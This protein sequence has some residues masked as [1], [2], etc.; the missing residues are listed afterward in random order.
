MNKNLHKCD[1]CGAITNSDKESSL[2]KCEYC[3]NNINY[4][5]SKS[6]K[7]KIDNYTNGINDNWS[8][9]NYDW[10]KENTDWSPE[11]DIDW[12]S[13]INDLIKELSSIKID[14][15]VLS[16]ILYYILS[17]VTC[18]F[19]KEALWGNYVGQGF[20]IFIGLGLT[21]ILFNIFEKTIR[22]SNRKKLDY[23]ILL[24][25]AIQGVS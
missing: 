5:K 16:R 10:P 4:Q 23:I 6:I 25:S 13:K 20:S 7:T 21:I 17:L 24:V 9:E 11:R 8:E 19:L 15:L 18:Y 2:I 12:H 14:D 1:N 22:R 3:G